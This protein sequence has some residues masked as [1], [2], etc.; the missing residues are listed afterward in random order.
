[1][2]ILVAMSGGVDSTVAA[3]LLARS[4]HEVVGATLRL[5]CYE[6]EDASPRPCCDLEAVRE[7][8]K[9][10]D[11]IGISHIVIDMEAEFRHEVVADFVDEYALGRTPNPCIRCNTRVKFGPLLDRAGRMG[12]DAIATGHYVRREWIPEEGAWS[13]MRGR[14]PLKDQSYVLWGLPADRL[15]ACLF[16][17]GP[18]TKPVVRRLARRIGVAAWDRPESQD[19][20][21]VAPGEHR[22]FVSERVPVDH[23]MR[24]PGP[25]KLLDG[26]E[27]GRHSGLLGWTIGQRHGFGIAAR[28][29]LYV[30]RTDPGSATLWLG[31]REA[32]RCRALTATGGNLLAPRAHLEDCGVTARIRYRHSAAPCSVRVNAN[33][34]WHVEFLEPEGVASPGQSV[35]FYRGDRLIGGAIIDSVDAVYG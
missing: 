6:R 35:V 8:R 19:I 28:E 7:A 3:W 16:P 2:R 17:L 20:C 24:R 10:A 32:V 15:A 27:V 11:R 23:P 26:T 22:A 9:S 14:D 4:G 30:V 33:G 29:R 13:L 1:M 12:F 25:V 31:T 5:F 21:F 18:T 34:S